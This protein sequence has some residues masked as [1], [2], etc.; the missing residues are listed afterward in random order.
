MNSRPRW[1]EVRGFTPWR[2][3]WIFS[4]LK[5]PEYDFL[6]KIIKVVGPVSGNHIKAWSRIYVVLARIL[7]IVNRPL[8]ASYQ[9]YSLFTTSSLIG[10]CQHQ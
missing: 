1:S 6:R 8:Q 10:C 5:N 9:N 2:D 3:R 4:E 7:F